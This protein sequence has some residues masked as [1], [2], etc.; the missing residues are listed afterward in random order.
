M[1]LIV[2]CY[3][4]KRQLATFFFRC[5]LLFTPAA[6][7]I[8]ETCH[9]ALGGRFNCLLLLLLSWLLLLLLLL[10][11]GL[12]QALFGNRERIIPKRKQA[13][14][15]NG[16]TNEQTNK[17][18]KEEKHKQKTI[19]KQMNKQTDKPANKQTNNKQTKNMDKQKDLFCLC[20]GIVWVVVSFF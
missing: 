20:L 6:A 2:A 5:K 10:L 14:K 13:N 12:L 3:F 19:D 11:F 18:Q 16:Q 9:L 7:L 1:L 15:T 8:A 17:E 4:I